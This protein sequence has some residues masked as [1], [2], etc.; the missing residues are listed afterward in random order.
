LYPDTLSVK[1]QA[2]IVKESSPLV[3]VVSIGLEAR[4]Y[5]DEPSKSVEIKVSNPVPRPIE[6]ISDELEWS[7]PPTES[8]G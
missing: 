1:N 6:G 2:C 4:I 7:M 5:S 3:S 8:M